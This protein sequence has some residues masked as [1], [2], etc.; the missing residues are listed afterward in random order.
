LRCPGLW[1][2][3]LKRRKRRGGRRM[4]FRSLLYAIARLLGDLGAVQKGRTSKRIGRRIAGRS[5]GK[6]LRKLFK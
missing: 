5:A 2:G 3:R 4:S 6:V 1:L